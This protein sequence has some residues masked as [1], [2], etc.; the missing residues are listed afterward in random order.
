M[1]EDI[2]PE[3]YPKA[4]VPESVELEGQ[5]FVMMVV[6]DKSAYDNKVKK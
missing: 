1:L 3:D 6:F 2:N 5:Q 4:S